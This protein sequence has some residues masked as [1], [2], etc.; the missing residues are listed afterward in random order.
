MHP[1]HKS[2][3]FDD[4]AQVL[5]V[6]GDFHDCFIERLVMDYAENRVLLHLDDLWS[7]VETTPP[8]PGAVLLNGVD[9][10]FCQLPFVGG[11][12]RIEGVELARTTHGF[13]LSFEVTT[14]EWIDSEDFKVLRL[15]V[16]AREMVLESRKG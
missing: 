1:N 5:R 2:D 11:E 14:T 6:H 13:K 9:A 12:V 15:E 8:Q 7:G 10:L 4:A 3:P 16:T